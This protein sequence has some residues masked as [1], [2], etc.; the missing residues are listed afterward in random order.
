MINQVLQ[1]QIWNNSGKEYLMALAIFLGL[2]F[3]FKFFQLVVLSWLKKLARK[4]KTKK[5]NL[6]ISLVENISRPLYFLVALYLGLNQLNLEPKVGKMIYAIFVLILVLEAVLLLQRIVDYVIHSKVKKSKVKEEVDREREAALRVFGQITK[7]F[8]WIIGF[9]FVLSNL[10]IDVRS[11]IAGVGI[12]G[13]IVA[14]AVKDILGDV[15]VSLFIFFDKPFR[16]GDYIVISPTERGVVERINIGNTYLR[17]D[18]GQR[19][20]IPNKK[21]SSA[22]VENFQKIVWRQTSV[23]LGISHETSQVKLKKI[24]QWIEE[25]FSR[26]ENVELVRVVFHD[27]ANSGLNF[28]VV[29]RVWEKDYENYAQAKSQIN[30][31]I[32]EKLKH[33]KVKQA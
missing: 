19:L 7:M 8:I 11:L 10:G 13:I 18:H 2:T 14:L 21:I 5:D 1:Y 12:G 30:Y 4:T 22:T 3:L 27:Y 32:F 31:D 20:I 17:A 16:V 23:V 9:I 29:F 25:I 33:E 6:A 15:F 28:K 24:P 26:Y